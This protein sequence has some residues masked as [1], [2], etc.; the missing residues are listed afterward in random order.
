[1]KRLQTGHWKA[2]VADTDG[3]SAAAGVRKYVQALGYE[4]EAAG[5]VDEIVPAIGSRTRVIVIVAASLP[6]L[7]VVQLCRDVRLAAQNSH[8]ILLVDGHAPREIERAFEA[9][10]DDV[11][12]KPFTAAELRARVHLADRVVGLEEYRTRTLGEGT[13]LAEIS[14]NASLH[15]RQYLEVELGRELDRARRFAHPIG[16]LLTQTHPP[17]LG[18]HAL[19]AYGEFLC[20]RLRTRVDWV[21]RYA[22]RSFAVVLPE[23]TLDGAA[24]VA[25][26]LQVALRERE[27]NLKKVPTNLKANIGVSAF[28]RALTIDVSSAQMLLS[29]AEQQLRSANREGFGHIAAGYPP[30]PPH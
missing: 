7:D 23:T 9:G 15:S 25:E 2:I 4:T 11:L 5:S 17:T 12:V 28:D 20:E 13:L 22:E 8:V 30:S 1:M 14:V 10:A 18:E 21:A 29:S 6:G 16:V 27:A 26:R 19:R 3:Q 24:R